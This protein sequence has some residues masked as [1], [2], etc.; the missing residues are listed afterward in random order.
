[1]LRKE[2][3]LQ[4]VVHCK[5][6]SKGKQSD[7]SHLKNTSLYTS[8]ITYDTCTLHSC[9]V[10]NVK[11]RNRPMLIHPSYHNFSQQVGHAKNSDVNFC[12]PVWWVREASFNARTTA[13]ALSGD[14]CG[15]CLIPETMKGDPK[16][17]PSTPPA[18][19]FLILV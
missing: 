7:I 8:Y 1:M 5:E 4:H 6:V 15:E 10:E 13:S 11:S 9:S 16:H 14:T 2:Q 19:T 3:H 18:G 17:V 12:L